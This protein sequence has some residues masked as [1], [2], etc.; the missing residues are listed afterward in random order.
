[1]PIMK[2]NLGEGTHSGLGLYGFHDGEQSF[3]FNIDGSAFIGKASRGRIMF[4]GNKGFIASANWF[5]G[6]G[7]IGSNGEITESSNAG[8]CINLQD[9]HIDAYNFK[10]KSNNIQLNASP[11]EDEDFFK[12][13]N[14]TDGY[15]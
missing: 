11:N 10:L 15:L 5:A 1:M 8:M 13:G 12:I 2:D 6:G 3:G 7:E 4:D 14:D 9:G